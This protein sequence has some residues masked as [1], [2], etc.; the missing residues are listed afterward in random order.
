M[1]VAP[2]I[3]HPKARDAIRLFSAEAKNAIGR[4]LYRLQLG[5][6]LS[7]PTARP[8]PEIATG[9]SELRVRDARGIYRVFYY[10]ATSEGILVIHAFEKKTRATQPAEI[11]IAARRLK[12]MLND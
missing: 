12:E 6:H 2:I 10:L 11:R 8:M 3:F 9:V 7:M 1:F 4:G 5:E